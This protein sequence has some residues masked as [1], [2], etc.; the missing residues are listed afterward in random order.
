MA[1]HYSAKVSFSLQNIC[2]SMFAHNSSHGMRLWAIEVVLTQPLNVALWYRYL[3]WLEHL[4]EVIY[5]NLNNI[6]IVT[7]ADSVAC[8][9]NASLKVSA[10]FI[11][12]SFHIEWVMSLFVKYEVIKFQMKATQFS[13]VG[14]MRI[15]MVVWPYMAEWLSLWFF[16][17]P[18]Q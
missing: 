4:T 9:C 11:T 5:T 12:Y 2:W 1:E 8:T 10:N 6:Y 13:W 7:L 15:F 16:R 3:V 14:M 18:I 17:N